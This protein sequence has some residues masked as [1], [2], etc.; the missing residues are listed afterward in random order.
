MITPILYLAEPQAEDAGVV[1]PLSAASGPGSLGTLVRTVGPKLV[2]SVALTGSDPSY[3]LGT[4][5]AVAFGAAAAGRRLVKL[6][7]CMLDRDAFATRKR[8]R[9]YFRR[10]H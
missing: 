2:K 4:D 10:S 6:L 5:V 9:V 7:H 1:E 3:P 8:G